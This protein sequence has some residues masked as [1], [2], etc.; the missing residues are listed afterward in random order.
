MHG[1]R[2]RRSCIITAVLDTR[3]AHV[4]TTSRLFFS[5]NK[6]IY[7]P[8]QYCSCILSLKCSTHN[9]LLHYLTKNVN[10]ILRR[11][12]LEIWLSG[13]RLTGQHVISITIMESYI[14]LGTNSWIAQGVFGIFRNKWINDN[15]SEV[16]FCVSG[17]YSGWSDSETSPDTQCNTSVIASLVSNV[18]IMSEI[19]GLLIKTQN[20]GKWNLPI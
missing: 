14:V 17:I 5:V 2:F 1:R 15:G 8:T 11:K 16:T 13:I 3:D 12:L 7:R 9:F 19:L 4:K 10:T 20:W 18:S 6:C